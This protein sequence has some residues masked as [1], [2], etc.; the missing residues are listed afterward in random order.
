MAASGDTAGIKGVKTDIGLLRELCGAPGPTGFEA[1][2]QEVLR[3][4]LAGKVE[5]QS[6]PL[7][8]LWAETSAEGRPHVVVTGHNDQIGLIVTYV[9]DNGFVFFDKVGGVDAQLLPGRHVVIHGP[10]GPV[11][12]VVGRKPT[13][14]IPKDEQ[15]KA[16]EL[17]EQF[18]D[19]GASSREEALERIRI[20]DPV[21]FEAMFLE[22]GDGRYA[23]PAFDDRAG[24]YVAFRALEHYLAAPAAAKLTALATVHEET[25]FMGAKAMARR[26]DADVI[27]VVDVDFASDDPS[28]DPKK[29]GGEVKLGGGPVIHR[30]AGSNLAMVDYAVEVAKAEGIP[31]QIKAL[32]GRTQTDAE[33]LMS[34]GKAATLSYSIP[35]RYMHSPLEVMQPD[36]AEAGALLGAAITRRLAKDWEPGRFVPRA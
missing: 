1:P 24:V 34:S 25:T 23:S 13:H 12:A 14:I 5:A 11:D 36:D 10:E 7:G 15:G 26:L 21:T 8:D 35:V 20:G 19:I 9:D 32:P 27:I 22:L 3:R 29:L 33:E 30:G 2:A 17:R 4:R 16:P 31:V 28:V 18:M 6:D